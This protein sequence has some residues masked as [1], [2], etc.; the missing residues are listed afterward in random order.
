MKRKM[1]NNFTAVYHKVGDWYI[2]FVEE[3]PWANAQGRTLAEVKA[4][5]KEAVQ[6][7]LEAN[8]ELAQRE[9][10]GKEVV[11]KPLAVKLSS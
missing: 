11:R 4:S 8:R 9:I 10:R 2:D 3:L 6:L 5:L 7:I 1:E